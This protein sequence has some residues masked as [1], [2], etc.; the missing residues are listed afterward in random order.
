MKGYY[1]KFIYRCWF[2]RSVKIIKFYSDV[3]ANNFL[4]HNK[5]EFIAWVIVKTN[6]KGVSVNV[7]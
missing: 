7:Y 3:D 6:K 2:Y 4:S 1:I 5:F